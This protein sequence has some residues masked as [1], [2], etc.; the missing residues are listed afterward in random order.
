MRYRF[1]E[2]RDET[3]V[4]G[5][6]PAI[7]LFI[8]RDK[9]LTA[10]Y[11]EVPVTTYT[12]TVNTT[13][14]GTTNPAPG[15]YSY[16]Q[17]TSVSITAYPNSG[18]QFDHWI[19][20]GATRTDNP[21]T[22]VMNQNHTLTAYF[23]ALPPPEF[24]LTISTTIGGTTNPT[25]GAYGYPQ[26][27]NVPVTATPNTN[28]NFDHWTLDGTT[29]TTNPITVL[30]NINHSV[31]AYF[32]EIPPPPPEKYNLNLNST[33]GG[34]TDPPTGIY[35]ETSGSTVTVTATPQA[36]MFFNHWELD[37]TIRTENPITITMNQDHTLLA[38]FSATPTIPEFPIVWLLVPVMISSLAVVYLLT[39][40]R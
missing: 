33:V 4:I 3:G 1:R 27:T 31:T 38:V 23:S 8:D 29:Y 16:T 21:I 22:V 2:W 32:S 36:D 18:Y 19:L 10:Y 39:R 14:G 15:T 25:P 40:K 17:G 5:T 12:L 9:T 30:M 34:S 37:G 11:E 24:T 6:T 35:Q 28:Y 13:V 20:D 26:N 7:S